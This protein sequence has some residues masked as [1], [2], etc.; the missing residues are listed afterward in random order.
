ME[1]TCTPGLF[2]S[3]YMYVDP[4]PPTGLLGLAARIHGLA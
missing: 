1:D 4:L 2:I 3:A